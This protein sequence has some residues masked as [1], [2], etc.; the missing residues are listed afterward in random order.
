V[1]PLKTRPGFLRPRLTLGLIAAVQQVGSAQW[2]EGDYVIYQRSHDKRAA[3]ERV[4]LDVGPVLHL[5]SDPPPA[6][7][8]AYTGALFDVSED[9]V[10][11]TATDGGLALMPLAGG[12]G[13]RL[14][15]I[16][17][18]RALAPTFAPGGARLAFVTDNGQTADVGLIDVREGAWPRIIPAD[19]DFVIDPTW[20]PDETHLAWVEWDV[21]NM[22][23][24]ES[25]IVLCDIATGARRAVLAGPGVSYSQPRWSPDGRRLAFLCDKTGYLNLWLA[26]ADGSNP[27][28]LVEEAVEHGTPPWGS[29]MRTYDWT[30]DSTGIVLGRNLAGSWGIRVVEVAS[31]AGRDLPVAPGV[32]TGLRCSPDGG[33]LLAGFTGPTTAPQVVTYN[34]QTG[35]RRV[36]AT[37]AVGGV[38][39]GAVAP[40][41]I[42]WQTPDGLTV[43]GL[44]YQPALRVQERA[45]LLIWVHGG[46]TGQAN[47]T[48]QPMIQY[49]V[50][51]G[52]AVLMP[53]HRGS[54]GYGRA[55]TVAERGEWGG[56]DM[57]DI[58]AGVD[59]V[60]ARGG[61]DAGRVVPIGGSAGG[62]AVLQ[63]LVLYPDR[64]KAG[65]DLFGISDHLELARTTHRLEAR[66]LDQL[67]GPLPESAA[68]YKERSPIFHLDRIQAPLLIL[69]GAEDRAVPV[70]QAQRIYDGLRARGQTVELQ[71]YPGEGHGWQQAT[72]VADAITR[73]DDFLRTHVLLR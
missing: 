38:E 17:G 62:Y 18:T 42:T 46:P 25:R 30:P 45:P 3:L 13:R 59:A 35:A 32:Y 27:R 19:S 73:I 11:Y 57:A 33:Y 28:P 36:L 54:A 22:G 7:A 23:W 34:L 6:G 37:G 39:E 65:V 24:D 1:D 4:P 44:L 58:L 55:F 10:V 40:Q 31:G 51:R 47:A 20:H 68:L 61:I 5:T 49:F 2:A 29:G 9:H 43:P 48:F 56:A 41:A 12:P 16:A 60:I 14:A 53:N 8:A 69:Q 70:A 67:L 64:F 71:I 63:L 21:P 52:W 26:D 66:Y 50:Q 15:T 72:T